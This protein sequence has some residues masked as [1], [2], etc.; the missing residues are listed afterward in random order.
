MNRLESRKQLLLSESELNRALLI[1]QCKTISL[2]YHAITE[3]TSAYG[4][5]ASS[6]GTWIGN[7]L[8]SANGS[9]HTPAPHTGVSATE[10]VLTTTRLLLELWQE[11]QCLRG[12]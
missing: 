4:A 9:H 10:H 11:I 8:A 12:K 1:Q 5:L 6:A 3:Q 2:G 7:K